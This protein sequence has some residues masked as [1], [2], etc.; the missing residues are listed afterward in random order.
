[1]TEQEAKV[2]SSDAPRAGAWSGSLGRVA[3]WLLDHYL[4]L[5]SL[6]A[7]CVTAF[8]GLAYARIYESVGVTPEDVGFTLTQ[9]LTNAAIGGLAFL[10]LATLLIFCTFIPVAPLRD[11]A[12][13]RE[14]VGSWRQILLNGILTLGGLAL[15]CSVAAL[16]G[17]LWVAPTLLPATVMLFF[18]S[19][20]RRSRRKDSDHPLELRPLSFR[21]VRYVMLTALAVPIGLLLTGLLTFT[22]AEGLGRRIES[23][24]GLL[25]VK[26][27]G[28]PFLGARAEPAL[29]TW[30]SGAPPVEMPRCAL[31]LGGAEGDSL[32]YDHRSE[33]TFR[34]PSRRIAIQRRSDMSDCDGPVNIKLPSIRRLGNGSFVC[35]R[36]AWESY[37]SPTFKI[38]W[39]TQGIWIPVGD[40]ERYGRMMSRQ[41]LD[42]LDVRVVHCRV[43]AVTTDG[44][45]VAASPSVVVKSQGQPIPSPSA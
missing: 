28:V 31:Y 37:L 9:V 27:A 32:F 45:G 40:D 29:I 5:G 30:T 41:I 11:D 34:V 15:M 36:G 22:A 24:E 10:L 6:I 38:E 13:A 39:I 4:P 16:V 20:F 21:P 17:F 23:G 2:K 35:R 12:A 43:S 33:S 44:E 7:L 8:Y 18:L 3:T 1:M 26:F 14:E 42:A 25:G 19:S